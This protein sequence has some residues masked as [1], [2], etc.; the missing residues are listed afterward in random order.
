MY[1]NTYIANII[2]VFKYKYT[3]ICFKG[4]NPTKKKPKYKEIK[5]IQKRSKYMISASFF[6][7]QLGVLSRLNTL[8]KKLDYLLKV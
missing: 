1:I 6:C 8:P 3:H 2:F 4:N 7:C 5:G